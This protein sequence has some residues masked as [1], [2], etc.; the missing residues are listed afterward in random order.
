MT[1]EIVKQGRAN[2]H[3]L[4][5]FVKSEEM[6][7]PTLKRHGERFRRQLDERQKRNLARIMSA[8][9]SKAYRDYIETPARFGVSAPRT[10]QR[11]TRKREAAR[12]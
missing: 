5:Q 1:N 7:S 10:A 2:W 3:L 12:T 8:P 9:D 11:K 6:G 4:Q